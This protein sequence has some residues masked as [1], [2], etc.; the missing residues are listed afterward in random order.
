MATHAVS[1]KACQ[2]CGSSNNK[3]C[4]ARQTCI[5]ASIL[6]FPKILVKLALIKL[7]HEFPLLTLKSHLAI[8][9][10]CSPEFFNE[11]QKPNQTK[12][13]III[14]WKFQQNISL[15]W[16]PCELWIPNSK[17]E[18]QQSVFWK[19]SFSILKSHE[20]GSL[21]GIFGNCLLALFNS[22]HHLQLNANHQWKTELWSF[23]NYN[24]HKVCLV[25]N[26]QPQS[27]VPYLYCSPSCTKPPCLYVWQNWICHRPYSF[28]QVSLRFWFC[29][30]KFCS[31]H[32][33]ILELR[34]NNNKKWKYCHWQLS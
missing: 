17:F 19:V 23:S 14:F 5:C 4:Q 16:S 30:S 8:I 33:R 1:A 22:F 2:T 7:T 3:F 28:L 32:I 21:Q 13:K 31:C 26:L 11:I 20:N 27:L 10:W 18:K 29:F 34:G 15:N 25:R 9:S 24:F 6:Y 12:T